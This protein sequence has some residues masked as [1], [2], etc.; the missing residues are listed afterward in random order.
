MTG[1]G[2]GDEGDIIIGAVECPL[3][4]NIMGTV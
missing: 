3:E 4:C 1:F 2:C